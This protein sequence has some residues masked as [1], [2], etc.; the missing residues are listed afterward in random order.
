MAQPTRTLYGVARVNGIDGTA[1]WAATPLYSQL[2]TG[3]E[4]TDN[5]EVERLVV[6]G[7]ITGFSKA[8]ARLEC[9]IDFIPTGGAS[10]N[11]TLANAKTGCVLP[12]GPCLVVL[13]GFPSATINGDWI[14]KSGGKLNIGDKDASMM[15]PLVKA[16]ASV[17][18]YASPSG[19]LAAAT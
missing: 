19:V 9:T 15:L 1:Q 7:T 2:M 14:Y 18:T 3:A 5:T 10:A 6:N 17:G 16:I 12:D 11:N 13:A 4:V 8:E